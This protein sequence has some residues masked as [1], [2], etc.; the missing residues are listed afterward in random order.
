MQTIIFPEDFDICYDDT[1]FDFILPETST[2]IFDNKEYQLEAGDILHLNPD[3]TITIHKQWP[4]P[5]EI[6]SGK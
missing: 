3:R 2:Y 4:H 1:G 5:K 6:I